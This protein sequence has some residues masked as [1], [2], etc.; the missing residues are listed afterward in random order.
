LNI[1]NSTYCRCCLAMH[2]GDCSLDTALRS[3]A[4]AA[5]PPAAGLLNM[6]LLPYHWLQTC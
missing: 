2:A 6:L 5:L 3:P 4:A 1:F